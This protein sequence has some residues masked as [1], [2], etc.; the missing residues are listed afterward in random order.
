MMSVG[1]MS[2]NGGSPGLHCIWRLILDVGTSLGMSAGAMSLNG[3]SPGL[4]CIL[5]VILAV[6]TS[7]RMSVG[8]MLF[9][10]GSQSVLVHRT[11]PL[12]GELEFPHT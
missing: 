12:P 11:A 1:A 10:T 3:G 4:H 5:R 9:S 2:L 7:L 6:G 8:A